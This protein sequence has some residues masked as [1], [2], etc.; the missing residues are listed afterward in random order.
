M[1]EKFFILSSGED[2]T[3]I[4]EITEKGI[5]EYIRECVEDCNRA[6][7][8]LD[9]IPHHDKGCW[10]GVD[11]KAVLIIKGEIIVPKPKQIVTK[12]EI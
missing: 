4:R 1:S 5:H 12:Y 10:M 8:F 11:D 2:G 6:P 3:S 9:K 7:V